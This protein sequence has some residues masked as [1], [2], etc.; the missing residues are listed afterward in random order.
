MSSWLIVQFSSAL[1]DEN[2]HSLY[3]IFQ[4]AKNFNFNEVH[5][6]I[7]VLSWTVLSVL[8]SKTHPKQSDVDLPCVLAEGLQFGIYSSERFELMSSYCGIIIYCKIRTLKADEF[9]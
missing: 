2:K 1:Y 3:K 4:R 8:C 6:T 5:L 7:F 9:V